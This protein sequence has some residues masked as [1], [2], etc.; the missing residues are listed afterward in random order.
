MK[1]QHLYCKMQKRYCNSYNCVFKYSATETHIIFRLMSLH[2]EN[3]T[4]L[5]HGIRFW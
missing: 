1:E 4:K 2:L 3:Q 5:N